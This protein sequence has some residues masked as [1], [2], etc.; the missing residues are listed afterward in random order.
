MMPPIKTTSQDD[1]AY[2]QLEDLLDFLDR[3]FPPH[4]FPLRLSLPL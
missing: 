2:G 3:N 1:N 4:E